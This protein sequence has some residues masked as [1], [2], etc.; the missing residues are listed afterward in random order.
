MVYYAQFPWSSQA[1]CSSTPADIVEQQWFVN[2][3][4][5][6]QAALFR[7]DSRKELVLSIPGTSDVLDYLT[8]A[9]FFLTAYKASGV[10]CAECQVHSGFLGAWN[11][12]FDIVDQGIK[13]ALAKYPS[14][15][16]TIVGH[17]LGAA[18]AD[19]AYGSLKPQL[20]NVKQLFTY[21]SPRVG[22]Q[23]FANY[24][25]SLSEVS[26]SAAGIVYRVTHFNGQ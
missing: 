1:P 4:T 12:V 18:L 15:T 3:A 14:Y 24:M 10:N 19:L 16:I 22:N 2:N 26:D 8:D 7:V 13:D 21:G 20:Q 11:S 9:D 23:A 6:T 25:D 5:K 17:S